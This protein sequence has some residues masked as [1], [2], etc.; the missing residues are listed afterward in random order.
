MLYSLKVKL[1]GLPPQNLGTEKCHLLIMVRLC[2]ISWGI[3][4]SQK[5]SGGSLL[6]LS[7]LQDPRILRYL[8]IFGS[9]LKPIA[10]DSPVI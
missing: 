5:L 3:W 2:V 1:S 9:Y 7:E 6:D 4:A 10:H 8:L